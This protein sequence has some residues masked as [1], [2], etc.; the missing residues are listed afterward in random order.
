[1]RWVYG[2][3][4]L[5]GGLLG[6]T[7]SVLGGYQALLS[8]L[9]DDDVRAALDARLGRETDTRCHTVGRVRDAGSRG[10][11]ECVPVLVVDLAAGTRIEREHFEL[12]EWPQ[13]FLAQEILR[14]LP[15]GRLP[16]SPLLRGEVVRDDRLEPVVR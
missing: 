7:V 10:P 4:W 16:R 2:L 15:T 3:A 5:V 6:A 12:R 8:D 1:M 9:P 11:V 13:S 14:E